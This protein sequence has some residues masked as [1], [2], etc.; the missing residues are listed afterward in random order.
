MPWPFSALWLECCEESNILSVREIPLAFCV[1]AG[2]TG[3]KSLMKTF[4]AQHFFH[5]QAVVTGTAQNPS[6][7]NSFVDVWQGG[8]RSGEQ[9]LTQGCFNW[10]QCC[11]SVYQG[12]G[13]DLASSQPCSLV[14]PP[15]GSVCKR[16]CGSSLYYRATGVESRICSPR[17]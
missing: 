9:G 15:Q 13:D 14:I 3:N 1:R 16:I 12:V 11:G 6:T 17:S 7:A 10:R 2:F 4:L 8:S 5:L